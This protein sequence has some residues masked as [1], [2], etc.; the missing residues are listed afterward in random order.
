MALLSTVTTM[1]VYAPKLTPNLAVFAETHLT[2]RQWPPFVLALLFAIVLVCAGARHK[3]HAQR[4]LDLNSFV[5]V[6]SKQN[7]ANAK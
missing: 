7:T 4:E 1:C 5:Y 2:R 3:E 6:C